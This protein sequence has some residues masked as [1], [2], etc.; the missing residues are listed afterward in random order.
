MFTETVRKICLPDPA[1][2][3]EKVTAVVTG[4]GNINVTGPQADVLQEVNVSTITNQDCAGL[5]GHHK[6]TPAMICAGA[7]GRDACSGDSGGPLAVMGP[8]GRYS[9]IGVV[10]WGKGCARPDYPGVYTRV[11]ALLNWITTNIIT[12]K[13]A[14]ETKTSN[15]IERMERVEAR[16]EARMTRMEERMEAGMMRMEERMDAKIEAKL[17]A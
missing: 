7:P 17:K 2:D 6:I 15:I 16:M 8:D 3:Y 5:H 13:P 1:L 12:K 9:Q 10:S 14:E 4:W 11:T